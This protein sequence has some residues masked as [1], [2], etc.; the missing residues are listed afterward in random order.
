MADNVS[1]I[2]LIIVMVIII[3]DNHKHN[4]M[5]ISHETPFHFV[6]WEKNDMKLTTAVDTIISFSIYHQFQ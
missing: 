5:I 1:F 4:M 3:F 2:C 6:I